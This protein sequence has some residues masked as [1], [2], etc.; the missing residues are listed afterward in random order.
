[1][2]W[3]LAFSIDH[4]MQSSVIGVGERKTELTSHEQTLQPGLA[5]G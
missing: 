5:S 3:W 4:V 2:S 1:M